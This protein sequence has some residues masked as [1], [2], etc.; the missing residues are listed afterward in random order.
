MP[1]RAQDASSDEESLSEESFDR[2]ALPCLQAT[3]LVSDCCALEHL[4][5]FLWRALFRQRKDGVW[6][7]VAAGQAMM[8]QH[9]A[10]RQ[11]RWR[12][13]TR[14]SRALLEEQSTKVMLP[15]M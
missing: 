4:C 12:W 10:S 8:S 1:G 5:I 3:L 15:E 13:T 14:L 2:R 11:P 6:S 9:A 7:P